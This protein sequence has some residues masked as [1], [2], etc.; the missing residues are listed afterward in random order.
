MGTINNTLALQPIISKTALFVL[1]CLTLSFGLM[2]QK[3]LPVIHATSAKASILDGSKKVGWGLD[4]KLKLDIY[5]VNVPLKRHK[6]TFKTDQDKISFNIKYGEKYDFVVL[7]NGKDSCF[8]RILAK[9]APTPISMKADNSYPQSIPFILIGS[10]IYFQGLLNGQKEVNVQFDT[11][12]GVCCVNKISSEKL[13]L[14]FKGK[15]IVDNTQGVNETRVSPGNTLTLT[16]FTW[17]GLPLVEVGNMQEYEDLIVGNGIF[18]DKI[19]EIDYDKKLFIVHDKLPSYIK[20]YKK[21]A[22][23]FEKGGIKAD[24]IQNGKKY[25]SWFGFDTGRDG[26]MRIGPDFT[27]QNQNWE[28]LKELQMLNGKKIV[29]LDA[30]ING[31]EFKD[32]VTNAAAPSD[33]RGRSTIFGNQILNHF[34]VILD[35]PQGEIY[36]K[37]NNR[38]DEPFYNYDSY[39]KELEIYQKETLK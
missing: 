37:P 4:P 24:I 30:I 26:A 17:S 25:T 18:K 6:V 1:L 12:A 34:N 36:L 9:E 10:R 28:N 33:P 31:V 16:N 11:G 38:K 13:Q 23:F 35:N 29:R 19:I 7:L 2:A 39:L 32:I 15:T 3:K 27:S 21:Q 22:D 8:T 20:D 5:Y 14:S